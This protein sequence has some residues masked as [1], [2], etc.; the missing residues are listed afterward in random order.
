M[1]AARYFLIWT[2]FYAKLASGGAFQVKCVLIL[3][4]PSEVL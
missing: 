4:L 1:L 2:L 3:L